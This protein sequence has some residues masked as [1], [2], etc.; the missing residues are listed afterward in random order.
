MF[1]LTSTFHVPRRALTL[2]ATALLAAAASAVPAEHIGAS[3]ASIQHPDQLVILSTTDVKGKTSPCGCHIPKGGFSRRAAFADSLRR[4][5]GQMVIVDCG[6]WFPEG[7]DDYMEVAGFQADELARSGADAVGVGPR[8]LRY[9]L[10]FL[11]AVLAHSHVPAVSAN[12]VERRTGKLLLPAYRIVKAGGVSVGIFSVM[13]MHAELGPARDSLQVTDPLEA[14]HRTVAEMRA[15]GATVIVLLA[16]LGKVEAEDLVTSIDG[17]DALIAGWNVPL[18]SSGRRVGTTVVNYGGEQG[19]YVGVT[20]LALGSGGRVTSG[21][22]MTYVLGPEVPEKA[23]VLA[24]VKAFEDAFNEH[25]RA[26]QR[27]R[28]AASAAAAGEASETPSHFVGAEVCGR[29]HAK[30]YAQWRTTAHSR[31]WQTLVDQKKESTP[32]CVT[33]HVVGHQQP[34]GFATAADAEKLGNVQCENCHGMGTEHDSWPGRHTPVPEATCRG[35]H[36]EVSSPLFQFDVFRPHIVHDVPA[37][38]PP[39]PPRPKT[40]PMLGSGH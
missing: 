24:R 5:F 2:A 33:C 1:R 17:I 31:A 19:H 32:D 21:D 40:S 29:C 7:G 10:G 14:A 16:N 22:N 13:S 23:E 6:G 26:H 12:L 27:E 20:L 18:L 4:E 38:L 11:N 8:E 9:G 37:V 36:T 34:G 25:E 39:L 35:C 28:A 3:P 15:R 30:E